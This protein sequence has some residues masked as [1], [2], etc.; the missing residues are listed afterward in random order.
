MSTTIAG[1]GAPAGGYGIDGVD[2]T[3]EAVIQ[4]VVT[5]RS[6]EPVTNAYVRLLDKSGEFTA[7][8][9]TSETGSFR[10]FASTGTWTLRVLAPKA[11]RVDQEVQAETGQVA[12]VAITI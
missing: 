4:G 12:D 5:S 11:D 8:V 7:E 9:Q 3:K 10:F 1:C 6:G 2:A